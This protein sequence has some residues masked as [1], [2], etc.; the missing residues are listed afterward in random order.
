MENTNEGVQLI[1][2]IN[3]HIQQISMVPGLCQIR[4]PALGR[5]M[6]QMESTANNFSFISLPG[7]LYSGH[8]R[9]PYIL[10]A[11]QFCYCPR[12][13][14]LAVPSTQD[15]L[16]FGL[17]LWFGS[18]LRW[19]LPAQ[20]FLYHQLPVGALDFDLPAYNLHTVGLLRKSCLLCDCQ[21]V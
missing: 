21:L 20:A 17:W 3:V 15:A 19:L 2:C 8:T 6:G 18:E 5:Q 1:D 10:G 13:F 16:L 9:L 12:V 11:Y 14:A 7:L 4:R